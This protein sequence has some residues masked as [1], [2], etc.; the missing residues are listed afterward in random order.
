MTAGSY[1]SVLARLKS[2]MPYSTFPS[3]TAFS[4]QIIKCL[5]RRLFSQNNA[6]VFSDIFLQMRHVVDID[7]AVSVG[8]GCKQRV[9]RKCDSV[10]DITLDSGR[11]VDIDTA[12]AVN[13][14]DLASFD[15]KGRPCL[16]RQHAVSCGR[17]DNIIGSDILDVFRRDLDLD[18]LAVLIFD[19]LI[20]GQGVV[21]AL[22]IRFSFLAGKR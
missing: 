7:N 6:V 12:V 18:R 16:A 1:P 10:R 11:V 17:G 2:K 22:G 19:Y 9:I 4:F 8:V 20:V 5:C 14:A 15:R 21:L 13:I 3:S